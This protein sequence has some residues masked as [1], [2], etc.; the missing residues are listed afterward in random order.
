MRRW[1]FGL[2]RSKRNFIGSSCGVKQSKFYFICI[3][4]R[5]DWLVTEHFSAQSRPDPRGGLY[6]FWCPNKT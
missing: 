6:S 5:A 3:L 1:A 4:G 2:S